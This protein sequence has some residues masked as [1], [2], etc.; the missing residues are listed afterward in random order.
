[1]QKSLVADGYVVGET[2]WRTAISID[3]KTFPGGAATA[4]MAREMIQKQ[5]EAQIGKK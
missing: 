3:L 4:K 5:L 1:M 2:Q